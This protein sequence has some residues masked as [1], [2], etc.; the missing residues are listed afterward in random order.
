MPAAPA[1]VAA[2]GLWAE[3]SVETSLDGAGM[4]VAIAFGTT[5]E[6]KDT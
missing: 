5:M 2:H 1:L 4:S 3:T 6:M